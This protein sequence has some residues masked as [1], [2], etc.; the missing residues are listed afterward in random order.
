MHVVHVVGENL[1]FVKQG[2]ACSAWH[3]AGCSAFGGVK[4]HRQPDTTASMRTAAKNVKR[5]VEASGS[6]VAGFKSGFKAGLQSGTARPTCD[7][8][9]RLFFVFAL[10]MHSYLRMTEQGRSEFGW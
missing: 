1:P 6:A 3:G 8:M 7:P 10:S 2:L 4:G 5:C 9:S